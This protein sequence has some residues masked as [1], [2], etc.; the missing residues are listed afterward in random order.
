[1]NTTELFVRACR[2]GTTA[3]ARSLHYGSKFE[4]SLLS[5]E[6]LRLWVT[7]RF[8]KTI[9]WL[10]GE[11]AR[12]SPADLAPAA[13]SRD[14]VEL[15]AWWA[16]GRDGFPERAPLGS[17]CS[18]PARPPRRQPAHRGRAAP[19]SGRAAPYPGRA[20]PRPKE[21]LGPTPAEGA[22]PKLDELVPTRDEQRF[23]QAD[24]T[25]LLRAHRP[26][27]T[28]EIGATRAPSLRTAHPEAGAD[29]TFRELWGADEPPSSPD[30]GPAWCD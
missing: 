26:Q 6:A 23:T 4:A 8:P 27:R 30:E 2:H 15:V 22:Q 14:W 24:V 17:T 3:A 25:A 12:E 16:E 7:R 18:R 21:I 13:P 29:K 9:Q 10:L 19:Y 11:L 20:A 5:N 1:M 28:G